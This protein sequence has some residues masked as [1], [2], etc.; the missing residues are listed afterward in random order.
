MRYSWFLFLIFFSLGWCGEEEMKTIP[1]CELH[2]HL[3]GAWPLKYLEG[4]ATPEEFAAL[5]G[6]IDRIDRCDVDY[7]EAFQ[8]FGLIATIVNTDKRVENG[9]VA[10]CK[11]LVDDN[12]VYAEFRTGLKDLGSGM[13]GFVEAVLR[14]I[15][16]GC[17][18]AQLKVGLI[19][20]VR[21]DT[22]AAVAEKTVDLALQHRGVVVGL[23]VSGDSTVGDG[24]EIMGALI[25]AKMHGLPLTLHIG[26]S[27]KETAEQQMFELTTLQ[28]ERVGHAVHL[29]EASRSWIFERRVPVEM[30]LTS[31]VK[32]GMIAHPKEHPALEW[33]IDGHPVAICTDD[34]LIFSTT[35]SQ[36]L[37]YVAEHAELEREHLESMQKRVLRYAFQHQQ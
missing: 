16:R 8:V 24:R 35:L 2:L 22:K 37:A 1:K 23:D 6:M 28:P 3:G 13:D 26:E 17:A 32:A 12:V 7:H 25:R 36:E 10:L 15:E 33:M 11:E 34:P 9:V 27:Q 14:G 4:I 29:H 20:S 19:L 18:G 5:K 21:R 30:C 31:A